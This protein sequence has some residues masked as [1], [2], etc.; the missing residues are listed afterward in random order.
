M[1]KYF[2]HERN[3]YTRLE[4]EPCIEEDGHVVPGV[5]P[6]QAEFWA[7]YGRRRASQGSEALA[8]HIVDLP[9]RDA[10]YQYPLVADSGLPVIERVVVS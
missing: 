3:I 1:A 7:V 4:I 5:D 6:E 2:A 10:A 9:S 8:D